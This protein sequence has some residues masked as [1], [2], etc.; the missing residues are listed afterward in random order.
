[1]PVAPLSQKE[2]EDRLAGLNGWSVEGGRITRER[3][4]TSQHSSHGQ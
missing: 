1:M 3:K 4:G 2:I